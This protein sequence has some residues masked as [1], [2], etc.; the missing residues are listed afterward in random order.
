MRLRRVTRYLF[1]LFGIWGLSALA[2]ASLTAGGAVA[3]AATGTVPASTAPARAADTAA[4]ANTVDWPMSYA[5]V[6]TNYG[7][8]AQPVYLSATL[9][10]GTTVTASTGFGAVFYDE[11]LSVALASSAVTLPASVAAQ[12]TNVTDV[13]LQATVNTHGAASPTAVISGDSVPEILP[14]GPLTQLPWI[15][16]VGTAFFSQP[17]KAALYLPVERLVFTPHRA[18]TALPPITCTSMSGTITS[19][20]VTVTGPVTNAPVYACAATY[21]VGS[22]RSPLPMTISASGVR[23]SGRTLTVTLSSPDTGLG[24]PAPYVATKVVFAGALPVTGAQAGQIAL[25]E[26]TTKNL[27][28]P[29]ATFTVSGRLRLIKR[30]TDKIYF[31]HR[32]TYTVHMRDLPTAVYTCTHTASPGPAVLTLKVT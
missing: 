1:S 17:G 15:S 19:A 22:Y 2:A 27:S 28:N 30:G 29:A 7:Y 26:T 21:R 11:G 23:V 31:P 5:C 4:L 18:N 6:L 13:E 8:T 12:L 16:A 10:F 3:V 24:A 25:S 32:F 20:A 9:S 14:P